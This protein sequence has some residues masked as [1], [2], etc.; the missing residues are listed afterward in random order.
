MGNMLNK[1]ARVAWLGPR[2]HRAEGRGCA[3]L[4]CPANRM[5][6]RRLLHRHPSR[7]GDRAFSDA[8]CK[9]RE[10]VAVGMA[11]ALLQISASLSH[12]GLMAAAHCFSFALRTSPSF[13][14]T[15]GGFAD[16]PSRGCRIDWG[17]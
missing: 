8:S 11:G 17:S 13:S 7:V 3:S 6:G 15:S 4:S 14:T 9:Q 10:G 16:A 1:E 12:L 2:N 5:Q